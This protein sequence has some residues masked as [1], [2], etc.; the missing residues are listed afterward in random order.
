M[1]LDWADVNWQ[2]VLN[3]P[4]AVAPVSKENKSL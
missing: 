2:N 4:K 3:G 1:E